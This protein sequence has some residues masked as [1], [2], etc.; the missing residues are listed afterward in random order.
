MEDTVDP[1]VLGAYT[2]ERVLHLLA[3]RH[4][5]PQVLHLGPQGAPVRDALP[6]LPGGGPA[7]EQGDAGAVG[8]GQMTGQDG[9][10]ATGTAGDHV[11][12]A[13]GEGRP[14]RRLH[15]FLPLGAEDPRLARTARVPDLGRPAG[16]AQF[17]GEDVRRPG[18]GPRADAHGAAVQVRGLARQGPGE[19]PH[20]EVLGC[21]SAVDRAVD[22]EQGPAPA[23]PG[24]G[25]RSGQPEDGRSGP[26]RLPLVR[27]R[28]EQD[29]RHRPDPPRGEFVPPLSAVLVAGRPGLDD[30]APVTQT[31]AQLPRDVLEGRRVTAGRAQDDV[32]L[33]HVAL[34]VR[35]GGPLGP[36]QSRRPGALCLLGGAVATVRVLVGRLP[37]GVGGPQVSGEAVDVGELEEERGIERVTDRL[38]ELPADA[39]HGRGVQAEFVESG[40]RTHLCRVRAERPAH[41]PAQPGG[42]GRHRLPRGLGDGGVPLG[43][44]ARRCAARA[45]GR[46]GCLVLRQQPGDQF[47]A[48]DAFARQSGEL[49]QQAALVVVEGVVA[50]DHVAGGGEALL[51]RHV[52]QHAPAQWAQGPEPVDVDGDERLPGRRLGL[53]VRRDGGGVEQG[54]VQQE[55]VEPGRRGVHAQ[56]GEEVAVTDVHGA[57]AGHGRAVA[58]VLGAGPR[59]QVGHVVAAHGGRAQGRDVQ[60]TALR[61]AVEAQ[62]RLE[63]LP[64]R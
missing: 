3:P 63:V 26:Y 43:G 56:L 53:A 45:G 30:P 13:L 6:Q 42:E 9:G 22:E 29:A 34:A 37:V 32:A 21:R 50:A 52:Q 41:E 59:V 18:R 57:M 55:A 14:P 61:P 31:G 51:G 36:E 49:G 4:V 23:G 1:A 46:V 2:D 27:F 40:V 20:G 25:H 58:D 15:R 7:R 38:L 5:G 17:T 35:G 62:G 19:G 39:H 24:S 44:G 60:R 47:G 64:P 48:A 16:G 12:P 10:E 8:A 33:G 54:G 11:H 28:A